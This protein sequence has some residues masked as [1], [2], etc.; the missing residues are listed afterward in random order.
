MSSTSR[1]GRLSAI[2]G[3]WRGLSEGHSNVGYDF[4]SAHRPIGRA[5]AMFE[6]DCPLIAWLAFRKK[7]ID[8]EGRAACSSSR[9]YKR[10]ALNRASFPYVCLSIIY[11]Q[12]TSFCAPQAG[13]VLLSGAVR[14]PSQFE[15]SRS[16]TASNKRAHT[17]HPVDDLRHKLDVSMLKAR[18]FH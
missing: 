6:G 15:V 18:A 9:V 3:H 13:R 10:F 4:Q 5:D 17:P 12:G 14:R 1:N 7:E 16:E 11:N 2:S 8:Y